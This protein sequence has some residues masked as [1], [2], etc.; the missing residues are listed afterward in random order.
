MPKDR[1]FTTAELYALAT[2]A[3]P[4]R[5]LTLLKVRSALANLEETD[6]VRR[7][8]L[9][10]AKI[11]WA[12]PDFVAEV[13]KWSVPTCARVAEK[14][15]RERGPLPLLDLVVAMREAGFRADDE[16]RLVRNAVAKALYTNR[17][18]KQDGKRW[19]V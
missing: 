5:R 10:H 18:F 4:K 15:L 9:I 16:P 8:R 19:T 12:S 1:E 7:S 13:R 6:R 17:Q 2:K 11:Q 3:M 14:V